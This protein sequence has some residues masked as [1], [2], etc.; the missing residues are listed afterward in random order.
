MIAEATKKCGGKHGCGRVLPVSEF[1]LSKRGL[2]TYCRACDYA[3]T[4]RW[5]EENPEKRRE[6]DR[7][8]AAKW[9]AKNPIHRKALGLKCS[10]QDAGPSDIDIDWVMERLERGVCELSGVPF[11]YEK[12]HPALP[13]I[14]RINAEQPGHMKDNCRVI[15]WGLNAFKG[16]AKEEV[17]REYLEKVSAKFVKG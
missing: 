11:V 13:S 10:A 16:A 12:L 1:Y 2:H 8:S 6:S 17:F 5:K 3:R 9:N 7:K 4:R 15:L 14:D